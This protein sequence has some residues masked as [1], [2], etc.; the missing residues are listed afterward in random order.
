MLMKTDTQIRRYSFLS[1]TLDSPLSFVVTI[2][3][4]P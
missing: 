4:D 3:T 1:I 2:Q